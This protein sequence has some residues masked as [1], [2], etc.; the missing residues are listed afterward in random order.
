MQSIA[1]FFLTILTYSF[2]NKKRV[3][4]GKSFEMICGELTVFRVCYLTLVQS[5]DQRFNKGNSN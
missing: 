4:T 2:I 1:I 5:I 3:S